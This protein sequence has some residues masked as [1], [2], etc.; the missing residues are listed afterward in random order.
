MKILTTILMLFSGLTIV[1]AQKNET[2]ERVN[3]L[4]FPDKGLLTVKFDSTTKKF[5][6]NAPSLEPLQEIPK[7]FSFPTRNT[8][9]KIQ[10]EF[11][12]PLK[13]KLTLKSKYSED[14]NSKIESEFF[15][16]AVSLLPT[17]LKP[18][19]GRAKTSGL[20]FS[21]LMPAWFDLLQEDKGY[22]KENIETLLEK[23]KPLEDFIAGNFL[24]DSYTADFHSHL[25]KSIINLESAT[26]VSQFNT[27]RKKAQ[28]VQNYIQNY[29]DNLNKI[30]AEITKEMKEVPGI[31]YTTSFNEATDKA[32]KRL[33]LEVVEFTRGRFSIF[34]NFK[35]LLGE[36]DKVS[37]TTDY[38]DLTNSGVNLKA[39]QDLIITLSATPL[40]IDK[41]NFTFKEL[42]K[43]E[44]EFYV[45]LKRPQVEASTGGAW[46]TKAVI[47]NS[48]S[49]TSDSTSFKISN[50]E[51]AKSF[52]PVLFLNFYTTSK[53]STN[54]NI[55]ILP[56]IGI[57]TGKE[58]PTV[59]FGA[60]FVIPSRLIISGGLMNAWTQSLKNG[61]TL[62]GTISEQEAKD[63][64]SI[65]EFKWIP[66]IYLSLQFQL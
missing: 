32:I 13:F 37:F 34:D 22:R 43:S 10:A 5:R 60:G 29:K 17:P 57:G 3:A 38:I 4:R 53:K 33:E 36:I 31:T 24:I 55:W 7:Y 19:P 61:Y 66:R 44:V 9:L 11:I 8:N 52:L 46:I 2:I 48:Y 63:I 1:V 18:E 59:L 16:T 54:D 58:Y 41:A 14:P 50:T 28:E 15:A 39:K 51:T 25:L 45:I 20:S 27:H 30:V 64:S 35:A 21:V 12:N 26:N 40:K 47:F 23:L 62:H 49:S 6:Y 65:Y 42:E 56:Q